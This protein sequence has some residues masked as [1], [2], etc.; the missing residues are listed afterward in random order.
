MMT[1][2]G[3]G[4]V[5]A[6]IERKISAALAPTRLVVVD[7]SDRHAGHRGHHAEGESHFRVEVESEAFRDKTRVERHR[8]IHQILAEELAGRVHALALSTNAPNEQS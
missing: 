2:L 1:N 3:K 8:L 6:A 7:E 4:A 5:K